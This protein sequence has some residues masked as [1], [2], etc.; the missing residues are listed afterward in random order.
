MDG[1]PVLPLAHPGVGPAGPSGL[2]LLWRARQY[3]QCWDRGSKGRLDP[4]LLMHRPWAETGAGRLGLAGMGESARSQE[5]L[6]V[7]AMGGGGVWGGQ[8]GPPQP[9]EC[10]G[11][12]GGATGGCSPGHCLPT[13][14]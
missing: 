7:G 9:A 14:G 11:H 8:A 10:S 13:S 3:T 4:V 2:P 5:G 12:W 6:P 1:Q